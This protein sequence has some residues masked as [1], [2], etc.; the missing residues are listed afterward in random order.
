M[1]LFFFFIQILNSKTILFLS[2][3]PDGLVTD[4]CVPLVYS[5]NWNKW[6]L[7]P[8]QTPVEEEVLR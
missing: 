6:N 5:N 4:I 3:C 7:S 1:L 8:L 2:H